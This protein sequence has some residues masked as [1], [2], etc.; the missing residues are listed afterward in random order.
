[1]SKIKTLDNK[2]KL[3]KYLSVSKVLKIIGLMGFIA[4]DILDKLSCP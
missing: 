3:V 2:A 1:M 4:R